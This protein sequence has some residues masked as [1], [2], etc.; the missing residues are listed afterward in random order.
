MGDAGW[1]PGQPSERDTGISQ[2]LQVYATQGGQLLGARRWAE[3][4]LTL[5][6]VRWIGPTGGVLD[7]F[8][9]PQDDDDLMPPQEREVWV[10]LALLFPTAHPSPA[11]FDAPW[12][13]LHVDPAQASAWAYAVRQALNARR[14][15]PQAGSAPH[16]QSY[17]QGYPQSYPQAYSQSYPAAP[18]SGAGPSPW[19]IPDSAPQPQ[20]PQA[21]WIAE[22]HM[23]G[24]PARMGT[25]GGDP[26]LAG[27]GASGVA[28]AGPDARGPA[29]INSVPPAPAARAWSGAHQPSP[30]DPMPD[31]LPEIAV[32]PSIEIELPPLMPAGGPAGRREFARDAALVFAR[33]LRPLPQVRELRGWMRGERLVLAARYIAALGNRPATYAE[34]ESA[35]RH[36]ADAL[37]SHTLPYAWLGFAEPGEWSQGATLPE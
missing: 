4:P 10:Q 22:Q 8:R 5:T 27:A 26:R 23:S 2:V 28:A 18:A 35:T 7:G 16:Y 11:G 1:G 21:G 3:N 6:H 19:R 36:V 37:A 34:V 15:A 32:L 14:Y 20:D 24:A 25:S 33:A 9:Q 17:P 29:P 12:L 30:W 13:P 31:E